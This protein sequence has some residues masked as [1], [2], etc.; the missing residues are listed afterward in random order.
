[1]FACI[2]HAVDE[3][4]IHAAVHE[5]ADTLLDVARLTGAGTGCGGCHDRI[6]D[7]IEARCGAC[8]RASQRVA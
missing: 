8:P 4:Q 5:G 3:H 7:L 2:C 1:M 6:E